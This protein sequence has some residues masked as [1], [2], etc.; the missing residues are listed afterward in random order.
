[1]V[2]YKLNGAIAAYVPKHPSTL[3]DLDKLRKSK[4]L[5]VID[6][7]EVYYRMLIAAKESRFRDL[8]DT[9]VMAGSVEGSVSS[10]SNE[11]ARMVREAAKEAK[12]RFVSDLKLH[13]I[14]LALNRVAA[15]YKMGRNY[16]LALAKEALQLEGTST[17]Q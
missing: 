14:E 5:S 6:R 17:Q 10:D 15:R 11:A 7:V 16:R 1:M 13:T 8:M 3:I 9:V 12:D 2:R 4:D